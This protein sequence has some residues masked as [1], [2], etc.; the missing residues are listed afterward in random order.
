MTKFK[1]LLPLFL[2]AV[3]FSACQK[4]PDIEQLSSDLMVYTHY[5][6]MCDFS[7]YKTFYIPEGLV[8]LDSK[9]P[10]PTYYTKDDPRARQVLEAVVSEMKARG[11]VQVSNPDDAD[12]GVVMAYVKNTNEYIGY[13]DPYWWWYDYYWPIDYWDPY[14]PGWIPYYPY[15]V[16]YSY[17]V[18]NLVTEII[19]LKDI[20][21]GKK[22]IPFVWTSILSG[23]ETSNQLN[24]SKAVS[25]IYQAF[26]QSPYINRNAQ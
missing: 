12:L 3:V 8:K 24:I 20:D 1:R 11:Y 7:Q 4:M 14:Y 19:A 13:V 16:S 2:L 9:Q 10:E 17:T 15:P 26:E 5:D 21:N 18:N 6:N 22:Q 23:I 25:G